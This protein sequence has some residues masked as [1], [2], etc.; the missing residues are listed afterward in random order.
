LIR[1]TIENPPA[2]RALRDHPIVLQLVQIQT[3][4]WL[5]GKIH[6]KAHSLRFNLPLS[7]IFPTNVPV[8]SGS[9]SA[10]R[11]VASFLSTTWRTLGDLGQDGRN[12]RLAD[13]WRA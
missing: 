8:T 12:Q 3:R 9:A 4:L 1:E 7:R 5:L 10:A 2:S 6:Q 11:I 13:P